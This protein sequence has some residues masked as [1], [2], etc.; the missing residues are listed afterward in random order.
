MATAKKE[1]ANVAQGGL[2]VLEARPDWV[3]AD[4]ARGSEEVT[5]NDIVLPRI[6]VLQALSPQIK[7]T[8][9]KYIPTA[10]Q[11]LI[12]NTVSGELYGSAI[13]FIPI[14]FKRE[15]IIWQDRKAGGGFRG[16]FQTEDE[17]DAELAT[18]EN[19]DGHEIVET[20][21][22]FILLAHEDGRLEE[23]VLSL[24]R[25]K[26]KVSRKLNSLVQMIPGDRFS[27]VYRL[28]AVEVSGPKGEYWSVDVASVGYASKEGYLRGQSVYNA[29]HRG[30]VAIDRSES[31]DESVGSATV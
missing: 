6:D 13:M 28:T 7:K 5:S 1:V 8:D 23:A 10:E 18:L 30:E 27:R 4:S 3:S 11:G 16:A 29:I 20:H 9:P 19:P 21:V 17:A 31:G 14:S 26:R 12:F 22:H 2:A 25:S 24:S 15:F